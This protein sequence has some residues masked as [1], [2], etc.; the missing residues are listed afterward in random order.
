MRSLREAAARADGRQSPGTAY[1]WS[2]RATPRWLR[3]LVAALPAP[4]RERA[5]EIRREH[6]HRLH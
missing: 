3:P 4:V 5:R 2:D 6:R 1:G